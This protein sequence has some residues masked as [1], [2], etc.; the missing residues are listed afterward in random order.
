MS[1]NRTPDVITTVEAVVLDMDGLMLDTEF[2][3]KRAWQRAAADLGFDLDD[4]FYLTLVGRDNANGE[5]ALR[6]QFGEQFPVARFRE[7]WAQL[8]HAHVV[9]QGIP[10]KPGLHEFLALLDGHGI[11]FAIATSSDREYTTFSLRA[12]RLESRSRCLVTG[13]QVERG[14]P[15]PDIYL[16]AAR[17]LGVQPSCCLALEDSEAGIV[18]AASAGMYAILIPDLKAPSEQA[19]CVARS[20]L[21]SLYDAVNL[22]SDLLSARGQAG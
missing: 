17:R 2:I 14:K 13:D 19:R 21:A 6:Q 3:Y 5:A 8:W 22:V 16:E 9:E 15:A 20:V 12:A 10:T 7:R 4:G 11:P 1:D 18:A